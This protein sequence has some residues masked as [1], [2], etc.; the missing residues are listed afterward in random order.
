[1][2][3]HYGFTQDEFDNLS[4]EVKTIDLIKAVP[5][6]DPYNTGEPLT[7]ISLMYYIDNH[8][9]FNEGSEPHKKIAKALFMSLPPTDK[10]EI[11]SYLEYTEAGETH[12]KERK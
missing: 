6:F 4:K 7:K 11:F 12:E 3:E 9:D 5:E 8:G 1:M 10:I 2:K